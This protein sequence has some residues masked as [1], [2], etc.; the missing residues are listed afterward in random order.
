MTL[1]LQSRMLVLA[2]QARNP[3]SAAVPAKNRYRQTSAESAAPN[4]ASKTPAVNVQKSAVS[5]PSGAKKAPSA[6]TLKIA[7]ARQKMKAENAS[8]ADT[9]K[10]SRQQGDWPTSS[11]AKLP[12]TAKADIGTSASGPPPSPARTSPVK[13]PV[14][15]EADAH[16][17]AAMPQAKCLISH[18]LLQAVLVSQLIAGLSLHL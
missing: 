11:P 4:F 9:A 13:P 18:K 5:A 15:A 12:K 1:C 6:S 3:E 16:A 14:R 10:G 7:E 8:Q 2:Q 17:A